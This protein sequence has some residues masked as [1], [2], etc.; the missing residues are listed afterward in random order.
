MA[1][2]STS[3]ESNPHRN[4]ALAAHALR[5]V[6]AELG[7]LEEI[8]RCVAGVIDGR[9]VVEFGPIDAAVAVILAE[10]LRAKRAR[11]SRAVAPDVDQDTVNPTP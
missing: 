3:P 4:A 1:T 2:A 7:V 9:A 6:L 11:R 5:E 10:R 8:P